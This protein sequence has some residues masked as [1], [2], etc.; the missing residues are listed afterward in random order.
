VTIEHDGQ[1]RKGKKETAT[2]LITLTGNL[3]S[4]P[5]F[6]IDHPAIV[7]QGSWHLIGLCGRDYLQVFFVL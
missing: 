4:L 2:M 7:P 1:A 6:F 5:T 3:R